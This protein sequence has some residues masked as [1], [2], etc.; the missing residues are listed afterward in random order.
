ME[1]SPEN[2]LTVARTRMCHRSLLNFMAIRPA[3][4]GDLSIFQNG[5][6]P[7][8]WIHLTHSWITCEEYLMVF[9]A[10]QSLVGFDAVISIIWKF[11]ANVNSR[12]RSLYAIARP[13]VCRL[14]VCNAR[15]P[16]SG[17]LNFPQYFYGIWYLGHPLTSAENFTEIVPGEPLRRAS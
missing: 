10:V 12:S 7:P 4:Y 14:S 11:L 9:I 6:R 1:K 17:G 16:Y 13:S 2:G 8:S 5:V 3:R 15:A